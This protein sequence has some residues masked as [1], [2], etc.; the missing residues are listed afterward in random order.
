MDRCETKKER[1][2]GGQGQ[3]WRYSLRQ[4]EEDLGVAEEGWNWTFMVEVG[5]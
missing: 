2:I 5:P 4:G 3:S 1:F